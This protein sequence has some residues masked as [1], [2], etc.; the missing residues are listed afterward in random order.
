M[1]KLLTVIAVLCAVFCLF[2]GCNEEEPEVTETPTPVITDAPS[3]TELPDT[4]ISY[5]ASKFCMDG[6]IL[7]AYIGDEK[8]VVIPEGVIIIDDNA[9][10]DCTTV[11]TVTFTNTV[12]EIGDYAFS[13]CTSLKEISLPALV[14]KVGEYAFADCTSLTKFESKTNTSSVGKYAFYNCSALET[15]VLSKNIVTLNESVFEGCTALKSLDFDNLKEINDRAFYGCV[16]L[17]GIKA[18]LLTTINDEVFYGCES[19]ADATNLTAVTG[20]GYDAFTGTKWLDESIAKAKTPEKDKD[21]FVIIG[22]GVLVY[23][24]NVRVSDVEPDDSGLV[25]LDLDAKVKCIAP[26]A[27]AECAD[28]IEKVSLSNV[29]ISLGKGAFQGF[30]SLKYVELSSQITEIPEFAFAECE[31]LVAVVMPGKVTSIGAHAFDGCV[32]LD[33]V[34]PDKPKKNTA[35][36]APDATA[37]PENTVNEFGVK[38][39]VDL[40]DGVNTIGEFA[41]FNCESVTDIKASD[42]LVE[43]GAGAFSYCTSLN[44]T[45]LSVFGTKLSTV[46]SYAFYAN[47][48]FDNWNGTAESNLLVIGNGVLI[49]AVDCDYTQLPGD[50]NYIA[51]ELDGVTEIT[52][53]MFYDSKTASSIIIPEGVTSIGDYAFYYAE[54]L[55]SIT[56]PSTVTSI[57][58]KAFYGCKNLVEIVL[59]D[60]LT[61]IA[62]YAFYGCA[63]LNS[64]YIPETVTKIGKYA[65]FNC[66]ALEE[67]YV[68]EAVTEVGEYAFSNTLWF[69]KTFD[70]FV[71][72]GD[73]ILVKYNAFEKET[74][75]T[76]EDPAVKTVIGGAFEG[77]YL[78]EKI[79]LPESVTVISD[80][81]F[82]G[83]TTIKEV[84]SSASVV[85][86]RAFNNCTALEKV[87]FAA[88][89]TIAEDAF[90]GC[91][92]VSVA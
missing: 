46:G 16:S 27:L 51:S 84:V 69:D 11:E 7:K 47:P 59:P 35:T 50:V 22:K 75:F 56:I 60:G 73:G 85:A 80:F 19:F 53:K 66:I 67:L 20:I 5:D 45:D 71:V 72:V 92:E 32:M 40:S 74:V 9:F 4:E 52:D 49:K 44:I 70:K 13:G 89:A 81:A 78:L 43:I 6:V 25:T 42:K 8:D 28:E 82:S 87:A 36:A 29:V 33:A 30:K 41:F 55:V 39:V 15:A 3:A 38:P 14:T 83:C 88:G 68:P 37:N 24:S 21:A 58:E 34:S 91:G 26:G 2:A 79:T 23:Y 86:A 48:W 77:T 17:E 65:F 64:V 31:N 76:A 54:N 10:R 1:K 61:E 63:K 12:T 62:D 90:Y 57:G 18:N